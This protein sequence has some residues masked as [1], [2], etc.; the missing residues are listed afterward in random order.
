MR[1]ILIL[2]TPVTA[3]IASSN[4]KQR[5]D[6]RGVRLGP[7]RAVWKEFTAIFRILR[8]LQ[9]HLQGRVVRWFTDSKKAVSI[10]N[11]GGRKL[12]LQV[13]AVKILQL[14]RE[15]GI[16][17]HPVWVSRRFNLTE[18]NLYRFTVGDNRDGWAL[19]A[20]IFEWLDGWTRSA[21]THT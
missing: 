19:T 9:S 14:C 10:I 3:V 20:T 8:A 6:I 11:K 1:V 5:C 4:R 21:S 18:A 17:L 2:A 16:V 12:P 15:F 7:H 13:V